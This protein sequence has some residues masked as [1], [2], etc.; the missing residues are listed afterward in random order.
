MIRSI[1]I[2]QRFKGVNAT[3]KCLFGCRNIV[4]FASRIAY[5]KWDLPSTDINA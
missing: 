4:N 2:P 1:F 5:V 3:K